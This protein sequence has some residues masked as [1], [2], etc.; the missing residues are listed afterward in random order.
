LE[1]LCSDRLP[2]PAWSNS[3]SK[4]SATWQTGNHLLSCP[5]CKGALLDL[6]SQ[7]EIFRK[8]GFGVA[9]LTYD[10]VAV[11]AHFADRKGIGYSLLS[12]PE[13]AAIRAFGLLNDNI[14]PGSPAYGIAFP[15]MFW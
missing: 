13:S 9:A 4:E 8:R 10:T 7:A 12:D 14:E 11:L 3:K 5:S 1:S 6:N 2:S 15:G